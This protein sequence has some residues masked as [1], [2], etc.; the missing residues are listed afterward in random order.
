MEGSIKD[1]SK[2]RFESAWEDLECARVLLMD[3]KFKASVN[4]SYYAIFHALR[5]VTALDQFDSSKHSGIIAYFNRTYIK[6]GIFDK[7]VSKM[8]DTAFR[9]R[10]KADY[11]DFVVISRE[12]AQEQLEKAENIINI[13]KSYLMEKWEEK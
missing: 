1:L 4:R 9:L 12:Q 8:I 2:Y 5:S 3:K 11:Q 13:L 7:S 10:E 6:N